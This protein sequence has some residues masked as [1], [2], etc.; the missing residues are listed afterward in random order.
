MIIHTLEQFRS[1]EAVNETQ[2]PK[3][4][5][6]TNRPTYKSKYHDS[7]EKNSIWV[8]NLRPLKIDRPDICFRVPLMLHMQNNWARCKKLL[9]MRRRSTRKPRGPHATSGYE[10]F[11]IL[12]A[13]FLCFYL[14]YFDPQSCSARDDYT[15]LFNTKGSKTNTVIC[16]RMWAL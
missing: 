16:R 6:H 13:S 14:F 1:N 11:R 2:N 5:L 8:Y 10:A 15:C 12:A 9:A 4:V 7:L 3:T